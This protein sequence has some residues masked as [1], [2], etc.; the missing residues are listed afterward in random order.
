MKPRASLRRPEE[1]EAHRGKGQHLFGG[2]ACR[3]G[4]PSPPP[5]PACDFGRMHQPGGVVVLGFGGLLAF[6]M[7]KMRVIP[8]LQ[9]G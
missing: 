5:P 2:V 3:A 4:G 7:G 8:P 6:L 9:E 1:T